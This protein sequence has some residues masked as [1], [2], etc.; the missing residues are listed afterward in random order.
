M[1]KQLLDFLNVA[2]TSASSTTPLHHSKCL[3]ALSRLHRFPVSVSLIIDLMPS[4]DVLKGLR[5]LT[6]H[7]NHSISQLS[8]LV[9]TTWRKKLLKEFAQCEKAAFHAKNKGNPLKIIIKLPK[10]KLP[11]PDDHQPHNLENK[12]PSF[13][14]KNNNKVT[15]PDR[16]P[17]L[18]A[19]SALPKSRNSKEDLFQDQKPSL[20]VN[21]SLPKSGNPLSRDNIR[22]QIYQA[23]SMVFKE[24]QDD[25]DIKDQLQTRDPI[26]IAASLESALFRKWGISNTSCRAKYR[27][28]LFNI[29]DAKNPDFRRKILLGKIKPEA[30]AEM[31]ASE[32][33]SDEMQHKND[34]VLARSLWKCTVDRN[35]EGTTDQFRCGKCGESKTIYHQMQTRSAD[36]PMTTYV[37]CTVCDNRWK[38]C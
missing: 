17:S 5:T 9:F 14:P 35:Q 4:V 7:P 13:I 32:M 2:I 12:N 34:A 19:S 6:N 33:A 16:K 8:S 27:S 23:L 3:S 21:S 26:R 29:K 30:V 20:K 15:A 10:S 11:N 18:K 22:E 24:S 36:E 38:F 28:L 25:A 37:T 1:E 31:N